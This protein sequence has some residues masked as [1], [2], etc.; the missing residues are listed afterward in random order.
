MLSRFFID[1]PIFATV[2]SIVITLIG[3]ISLAWL[4]VA[5]YPRITPP[6]V[7]VAISYPGASAQVVADT[8]AAPLEQSVTGVPG[9]LYMSSQSGND[10]SYQMSV[11]FDVATNLNTALVMVQNRVSLAM[12][13]LPTPVQKQGITIR[14]KTPDMLMMISLFS[15]DQS[16]NDLYLSNYALINLKDELLRVDGVSD[17]N[18]Q[19]QRDYSIRAWLDP[20][21]LAGLNI[22]ASEV[23]AAIRSQNLEVASGQIGQP[24]AP[25]GQSFQTPISVKGRLMTEEEFGNIIIKAGSGRAPSAPRVAGKPGGGTGL[26][27]SGVSDPLQAAGKLTIA[28]NNTT[29]AS[30]VASPKASSA[31]PSNS[32]LTAVGG[33]ATGGGGGTGGG[34]STA[35]GGSTGGGGSS[36]GG[37]TGVGSTA[38]ADNITEES[39]SGLAIGSGVPGIL[40]NSGGGSGVRGPQPAS[41]GIVRLRDVAR[42]EL[43]AKNYNNSCNFNGQPSA[44]LTVYQL[45]GTNALD[46]ADLVRAKMTTLKSRFPSGIDYKIG[47]DTTL[48]IRESVNEVFSTLI[49][50]V[51]LVTF[52][53]LLF[54]QDWKA[55]ILPIIDVPVS[56]IGTFGVM[57]VMGFS[58]N[59]ISLFGLVLAIGIVVD[60]AIV[61]LENIERQMAKGLDTRSA[62]IKAM[63]EI[64]GPI[65]AITIVLCAVFIPCAFISGITGRFFNQFAVTIAASTIISALNALTMTPSRALLIFK[66][67]NPGH[68]HQKVPL[69]WWIFGVFGGVALAWFGP[70]LF[71]HLLEWFEL[72]APFADEEIPRWLKHAIYFTPGLIAGLAFG[73]FGIGPANRVMTFL[74]RGFNYLFDL[75]TAGY[76]GAVG[77]GMRFSVVVLIGYAGLLVLTYYVFQKAPT[78]F[79]PQQDQGR[80]LVSIQLPDSASLQRTQEIIGKVEAIAR[81]APG[82]ADTIALGGNS[83]VQQAA[84]PNFGSMFLILKPFKERRDPR[85]KDE[86]I[87]ARLRKE[88]TQKVPDA[89]VVVMGS[90][91]IP[92]LSSSGGFKILVEDKAGLGLPTLQNQTDKLVALL[93]KEP[94][95]ASVSTQFRSSTPQLF[96]DIDRTKVETLEL[97][98]DDV[99]QTMQIFVGS[100]YV[101]SFNEF[102]RQWQVTL[103]AEGDFRRLVAKLNL[104]QVR[105]K[106]GQMVPLGTLVRMKEISG[107]IFITRFNLSTAAPITGSLLPGVSSGEVIEA[108][109]RLAKQSL[110]LSMRTEWTELMYMQI[111]E[112]NTAILVF[113]LGVM[114]VFLALAALY[115]SW[116][117]PLAVILVVPL[118][119]LCSVVGVLIAGGSVNIFV[120]IGLV[121][122]VG[123]ACKNAILVVEFARELHQ[124][125]MTVFEA[126]KEASRLRLRPILMTSFAFILGVVP[127]VVASG[128][129]AEMRKSLGTAVFSGMLGV[130]VFGVFLTPVFYYV[131]QSLGDTAFFA[132]VATQRALSSLFAGVFG[133]AA[134]FLLEQLGLSRPYVGMALGLVVGVLLP[135]AIRGIHQKIT[136]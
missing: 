132:N 56:L 64:T 9:M 39:L 60:D 27:G 70:R 91:P 54:L 52:V 88:W 75:M 10:G 28:P 43:A 79:V 42:I 58:L 121:V 134:G 41:T 29:S 127:L 108:T 117:L 48:F 96:M 123:L 49:D 71:A 129:G 18:I 44:G 118:C 20:Q 50:A 86:A 24:P 16:R 99:N 101:N 112:G 83:F 36:G 37:A 3:G 8:I 72:T 116:T 51:L 1:R 34:A 95:L 128:A 82:V 14:K 115:E 25:A 124:G 120:Q 122:L 19:G 63:E 119:V 136:R 12:P 84:S 126:T 40:A 90:S 35:G 107:P 102:G 4:P 68:A 23:A 100:L 30:P 130:T 73:W 104:F 6:S 59:N 74:F 38:T 67:H 78:G 113:A 94:G 32:G 80:L 85:L 53:V 125:G 15:P 93:Q 97:S 31:D 57:A 61:V 77:L 55:M 45:P 7:Q 22:S 33:A 110:P 21:R 111:R 65:I 76:A 11:T 105:N 133:L 62:T 106:L 69:P 98:L 114:C 46:V 13:L 47:Y 17:I 87:M 135:I 109:E 81:A 131:I 92:G 5:Q 2:L 103:Q 26:P 89:K 66:N